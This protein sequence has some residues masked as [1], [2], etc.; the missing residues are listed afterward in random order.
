MNQKKYAKEYEEYQKKLDEWDE[1]YEQSKKKQAEGSAFKKGGSL[2]KAQDGP[3]E[4][5]Y[6]N[7][8][9]N[10]V[11]PTPEGQKLLEKIRPE[12]LERASQSVPYI[13]SEELNPDEAEI[14]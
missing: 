10:R 4:E 14:S 12:A 9:Q 13:Y 11:M 2:P 1:R 6:K 3:P 5:F 8:Y 7:W